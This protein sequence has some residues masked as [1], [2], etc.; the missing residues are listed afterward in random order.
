M[1]SCQDS[2]PWHSCQRDKETFKACSVVKAMPGYARRH[3]SM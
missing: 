3:S 2:A 1:I